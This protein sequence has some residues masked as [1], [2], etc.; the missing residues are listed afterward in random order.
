MFNDPILLNLIKKY[1]APKWK[2]KSGI[3]FQEIVESIIG[4]Q[5]SLKAAST[6]ADRFVVLFSGSFPTP[7][8]ILEM[9]REKMRAV[10]MSY[11]KIDYIKSVA[12]AFLKGD[13]SAEKLKSLS[14]DEIT[15]ELTKLKGIGPWTAEMILIFTLNRPD[16]FSIGDAG[17]KRAIYKLY[18]LTKPE[19]ILKLS[20]SW[21]PHRSTAAWYLWRSLENN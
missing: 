20:E 8:Q 19:E 13:I 11:A 15:E 3:L 7:Q 2:D 4:Q 1:P 5:L 6:I 17:L 18:G 12:E 16:I 14:D 10:G 9:D 21:K